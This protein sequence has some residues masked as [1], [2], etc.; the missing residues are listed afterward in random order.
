MFDPWR[1]NS[2]AFDYYSR[3]GRVRELV[4]QHF[5]EH[6]PLG[7]AAHVACLERKYFSSFFRSKTGVC[8][9]DWLAYQRSLRAAEL[10]RRS[11]CSTL[12]VA[13]AVGFR[14]IRT[15]ER[16]FKRCMGLTPGQYKRQVRPS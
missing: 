13:F 3:L 11:N 10:M 7:R 6:I 2:Q 4:E 9:R 12:E 1:I 14:D 16:S 8:F 15:F 5:D